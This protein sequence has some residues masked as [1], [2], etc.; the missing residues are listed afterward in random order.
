MITG[1]RQ[2]L[3]AGDRFELTLL[4]AKAR[5]KRVSVT[6]KPAGAM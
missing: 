3:R 4:F 6:V 5:P 2:P 1:L